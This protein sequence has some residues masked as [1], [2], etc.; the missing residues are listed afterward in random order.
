LVWDKWDKVSIPIPREFR[1][2]KG[3]LLVSSNGAVRVHID[4]IGGNW[5]NDYRDLGR[6][7]TRGWDIPETC[8]MA[9]LRREFLD[10]NSQF[11]L[12]SQAFTHK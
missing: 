7:G 3:Q 12:V 8:N 10:D 11:Q 2:G 4:W 5:P 6:D 1:D 9:T